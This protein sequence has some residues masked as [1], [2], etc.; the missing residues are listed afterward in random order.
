MGILFPVMGKVRQNAQKVN[1]TSN[2]YQI[3]LAVSSYA[4]NNEDMI[5]PAGEMI[6][7]S[8]K[9]EAMSLWHIALLPYVSEKK[10]RKNLLDN[11]ADIWFCPSDKDPYPKGFKFY[12]HDELITSYAPNGYYPQ[13]DAQDKP[14]IK[15][16]PCGGYKLSQIRSAGE[17]MLMGET[18]YAS[19]FYDADAPSVIDLNLKRDGHHRC[20]SGFYHNG[21]MNVLFVDGHVV[22]V[23]GKKTNELV[24]PQGCEEIYKSGKYKYWPD[25]KLPGADEKPAFWGP[26]Y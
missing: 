11:S 19:Q 10:N 2:L 25:L 24:W 17:C 12:P 16:G 13:L 3:Y 7:S 18:S 26:G 23:R 21:F 1:C 22:P 15:L 4:V 14:D 9:P 20:T 5:V 6:Y 8:G